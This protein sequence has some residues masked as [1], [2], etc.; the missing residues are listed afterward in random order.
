MERVDAKKDCYRQIIKAVLMELADGPNLQRQVEDHTIFDTE[1]DR[2]VLIANG[3]NRDE[4]VNFIVAHIEIIDGKV[5]VQADNTDVA[6]ARELEHAGVAPDDIV[7]GFRLPEAD[8][9]WEI[10]VAPLDKRPL[11]F[12]S[13]H[14]VRPEQAI[15]LVKQVSVE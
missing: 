7:L 13:P 10:A 9:V 2:Y 4:R 14:L 5:W 1:Q 6:V 15:E 11:R 8:E 12:V 3:W